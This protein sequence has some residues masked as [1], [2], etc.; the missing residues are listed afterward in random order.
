MSSSRNSSEVRRSFCVSAGLR[1]V[2]SSEV[3]R[4]VPVAYRVELYP[5]VCVPPQPKSRRHLRSADTR[6]L[7]VRQTRAVLGARDLAV[8]CAVSRLELSTF[9]SAS[10]VTDCCNVC[11]TL[12]NSPVL[13]SELA[14]LRTVYFARYKWTHYITTVWTW[15]RLTMMYV[16]R[17]CSTACIA[18]RFAIWTILSTECTP[19]GRILT[20]RSSTSLLI[21]A[22]TD[23]MSECRANRMVDTLNSCFEYLFL[24]AVFCRSK[25]MC[26]FCHYVFRIITVVLW[27]KK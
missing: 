5:T 20:N 25:S 11:Q 10:L 2:A 14:H 13:S 12:K 18:F 19:A 17:L 4:R 16:G 15:T 24:A 9:R 3:D 27:Q 6:K 22:V 23:W 7:V 21:S 8:S 1:A 26:A